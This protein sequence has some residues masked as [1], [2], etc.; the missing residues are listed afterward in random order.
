MKNPLLASWLDWKTVTAGD[1]RRMLSQGAAINQRDQEGNTPLMRSLAQ[2][3]SFEVLSVL[4][5]DGFASGSWRNR[6]GRTA[7]MIACA[8]RPSLA[9]VRR[10]VEA[11]SD[12]NARDQHGWSA[13]LCAINSRASLDVVRY[14]IDQGAETHLWWW[15][16]PVLA[17]DV[18]RA[19]GASQAVTTYLACREQDTNYRPE[20]MR[21]YDGRRALSSVLYAALHP[22]CPSEPA[23]RLLDDGIL[24]SSLSPVAL[25]EHLA[26]GADPLARGKHGQT[27]LMKALAGDACFLVIKELVGRGARVI[28]QND[29]GNTPFLL[30]CRH[31]S[32]TEVLRLLRSHGASINKRN[33]VHRAPLHEAVANP[34]IWHAI[35]LLLLWQARVWAKDSKGET[36]L[37][38]ALRHQAPKS[39]IRHLLAYGS[40]VKANDRSGWTPMMEAV[41][42]RRYDVMTLLWNARW[43]P[44]KAAC[45]VRT[46]EEGM[47]ALHRACDAYASVKQIKALVEEGFSLSE[48]DRTGMTALH[49]ACHGT[50]DRNVVAWMVQNGA[51]VHAHDCQGLS[52]LMTALLAHREIGVIRIL[53]D[54]GVNV[55]E[56]DDAGRSPLALA[57]LAGAPKTQQA[58]ISQTIKEIMCALYDAGKDW[59]YFP[60][61]QLRTLIRQGAPLHAQGREGMGLLHL[62]IRQGSGVGKIAWLLEQGVDVNGRDYHGRT[63]LL[64][65]VLGNAPR[66]VISLL[67]ENGADIHATDVVGRN[68]LT[69]SLNRGNGEVNRLLLASCGD[70][71]NDTETA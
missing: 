5:D 67:L 27:V 55:M 2:G 35:P 19:S 51:D 60:L 32:S 36:P 33:R 42:R 31:H 8:H 39:V 48:Q 63:P 45:L 21:W 41:A 68:P 3:V 44:P 10:L 59:R 47:T 23:T 24:W 38:C 46:E 20:H 4:L 53:L 7:L 70:A 61:E 57:T 6:Q 22:S 12:I 15:S 18:A 54:A 13:L 64:M 1:V 34:R 30:A 56:C 14:M 37:L 11:G 50:M 62:A 9:V 28:D 52:P 17:S 29:E 58:L 65:A 66:E 69:S 40:D 49:H 71:L 26:S 16:R 25:R 43:N